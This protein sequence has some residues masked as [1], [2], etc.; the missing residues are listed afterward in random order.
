MAWSSNRD[1]LVVYY[2]YLR[3]IKCL[4]AKNIKPASC[5]FDKLSPKTGESLIKTLQ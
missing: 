1:S 2:H 5:F 4:C 3:I